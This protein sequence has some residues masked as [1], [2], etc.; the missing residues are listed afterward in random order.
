MAVRTAV[1]RTEPRRNGNSTHGNPPGPSIGDTGNVE[2]ETTVGRPTALTDQEGVNFVGLSVARHLR[3]L[4]RPQDVADQ[5]IDA[6]VELAKDGRATGRLLALQIKSG[7]SQFGR[8]VDDGWTFYYSDRERSLWNGHV[9]PVMVVLVDIDNDIA[10]WQRIS[11]LTERRTKKRYAVH[12]PRSQTL[13]TAHDAWELAASGLEQ[14]AH[15]RWRAHLEVLPPQ[16][17][18]VLTARTADRS[19]CELIALHLA[20][21]RLDAAGTTRRLLE[22]RPLWMESDHGWPWAAGGAYSARHEAMRETSSAYE[23]AAKHGGPAAGT[24]LGAAALHAVI[25]PAHARALIGRAE[26]HPGAGVSVAFAPANRPPPPGAVGPM[27]SDGVMEA[28]GSTAHDDVTVQKF[29]AAQAVHGR[30]DFSASRHAERAFELAPQDTDVMVQLAGILLR[31]SATPDAQP[32]DTSRAIALL[33]DAVAQLRRWSGPSADALDL[34]GRALLVTS[35]Y[36]EALHWLLPEPHG[37][38]TVDEFRTP[39][40]LRL[41]LHAAHSA[42]SELTTWVLEQMGDTHADTV[43]KVRVGVL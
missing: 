21:G 41:A 38:S 16:V 31:R 10:Y 2:R 33:R 6:H 11:P 17:A 36:E 3:W 42:A 29:L 35:Q 28:A 1:R 34:L 7:P 20:E 13:S 25:D 4:F 5:G 24:F 27:R 39:S 8:K 26:G 12:V 43:A 32:D 15:E 19:Q 9:L 22:E 37:T 30:D 14:V 23:N 18:S 40:V